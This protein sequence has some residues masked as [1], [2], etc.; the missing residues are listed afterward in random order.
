M[1]HSTWR[2]RLDALWALPLPPSRGRRPTELALRLGPPPLR[3]ACAAAG[4]LP[5]AAAAAAA[6]NAC[7]ALLLWLLPAG[8]WLAGGVS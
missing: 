8:G 5:S 2:A 6:P 3:P 7:F 4:A 1:L